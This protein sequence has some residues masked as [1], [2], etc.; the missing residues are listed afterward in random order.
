ME[1]F[2]KTITKW[3]YFMI[4]SNL[5][6]YEL[7]QTINLPTN[8]IIKIRDKQRPRLMGAHCSWVNE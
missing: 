2:Y 7:I 5:F 1:L 6:F 3:N 4:L 8:L